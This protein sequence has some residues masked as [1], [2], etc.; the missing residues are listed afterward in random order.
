MTRRRS[1]VRPKGKQSGLAVSPEQKEEMLQIF[2]V[3]GNKRET[4]RRMGLS[5]GC[6]QGHLKRLI[7]ENDGQVLA[8]RR[9]ATQQLAGKVHHKAARIIDSIGDVDIESG[10]IARRNAAGEITGYQY[11]GPSLLQK[12]TAGAILS[13][14][15][16]V[17]RKHEM[18]LTTE[19]QEGRLLMPQTIE[20]LISGIKGKVSQISV[21]NVKF[22]D[23]HKDLS[24]RVQDKLEEAAVI[25][26]VEVIGLDDLDG[27]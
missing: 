16:D 25:E 4:A 24:Q 27:N 20:G 17:L 26:E 9:Q 15:L 14:K 23:E 8:A 22:E 21:L 10:R 11:Y 5:E 12:V 6:V 18:L 13:D 1:K 3:T 19:G 7:E 2:L